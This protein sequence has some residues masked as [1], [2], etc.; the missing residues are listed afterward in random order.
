MK[1]YPTESIRNFAL[2]GANGSGKTSIAEA[3]LF[4]S[5]VTNRLGKVEEGNTVMDFDKDEI[6]KKMSI[7]L[8]VANLEWNK[9]KHNIVDTPGYTDFKGDLI[10]SLRAVETALITINAVSGIEVMTEHAI[11]YADSIKCSKAIIINKIGKENA[12]FNEIIE[13]FSNICEQ[14]VVPVLIPIGLGDKFSGVI[15]SIIKKAYKGGKAIN[16]PEELQQDVENWHEKVVEAAA[17]SDDNLME[18]YF[19]KG[20]LSESEINFGLKKSI[21]QCNAIP[22]FC[23]SATQNIGVKETMNLINHFFPSPKDISEIL[24][25]KNGEAE[26]INLVNYDKKLGYVVK[27]LSEPNLGEIAIVRMYANSLTT[28]DEIEITEKRAKDKIGQIYHICGRSREETTE[29]SAGDI[30]GL[31]K[32]RNATTSLSITE[33]GE[34]VVVKPISFPEPV[35]WKTIKALSQADEDKIGAALAK[36]TDGDPTINSGMN[37]ETNENIIAGQGEIQIA[38][39]QKRLK[40]T[41]NV[42]TKLTEPKIPYKETITGKAAAR[43]RHKKQSGGHGQYGEV[44]IKISPRELGT[45]FEFVNSIV[46]GAIPSKFIPAVEKGVVETMKNG[47]LANYPVVDICVEL[48][49]GTF[50]EVDSSELSF[51]LAAYHALKDGFMQANPILLEPIHRIQIVVLTENMGDVMGDIS[52]RRG[53]ILGMSQEDNKQVI[54]AEMPLSELYSYHTSLKSLTQG[55]GYFTQ[56]FAYY[57]KLPNDLAQKV[58]E[59]SKRGK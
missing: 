47:I 5:G 16:I 57:Q 14:V 53:K 46:G 10:S 51:K 37:T 28:G 50:H 52:S 31:V 19:D 34:A 12:K 55:K 17:E 29:I 54:N 58:I 20:S 22:V 6:E 48:Y 7:S 49:D 24:V 35:Y 3:M 25:T 9:V 59:E 1:K 44:Y 41:Y 21:I 2:V 36:I 33:K 23:C 8:S 26:S 39:V 18:K 56:H 32:L 30:G 4:N 45:G 38:V 15:N 11:K 27:S 13:G 40:N 43:Y 42:A